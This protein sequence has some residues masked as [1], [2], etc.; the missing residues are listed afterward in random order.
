MKST[1]MIGSFLKGKWIRWTQCQWYF[2]KKKSR[3]QGIFR[4]T[5]TVWPSSATR[6]INGK[7][8]KGVSHSATKTNA[9]KESHMDLPAWQG[10][11]PAHSAAKKAVP[12]GEWKQEVP[13]EV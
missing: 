6:T 4:V 12:R 13:K 8:K 9:R 10:S 2:G 1:T 7:F 5:P 11:L 3:Q